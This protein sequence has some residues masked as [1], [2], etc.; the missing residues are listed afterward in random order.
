[1]CSVFVLSSVNEESLEEDSHIKT[2]LLLSFAECMQAA[3]KRNFVQHS[4]LL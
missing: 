2:Q 4:T 1:M 3:P